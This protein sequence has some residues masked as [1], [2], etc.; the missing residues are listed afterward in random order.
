MSLAGGITGV[1]NSAEIDELARFA[2]DEHNKKESASLEFGKVIEAKQQV[3]QGTMY[4]ITLEA[5]DGGDKKTY[6]A[7][8]WVKPWE[9]FRELQELKLV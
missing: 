6:E 7:K 3:V 8:V 9:N 2:I 1:E 4:Y 5:T